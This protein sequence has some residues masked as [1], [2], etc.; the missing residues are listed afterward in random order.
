M[1]IKPQG[2]G[3]TVCLAPPT[4]VVAAVFPF[5]AFHNDLSQSYFCHY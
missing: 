3:T 5:N 2:G 4:V 1:G